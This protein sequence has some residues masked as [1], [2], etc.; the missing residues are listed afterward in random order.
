[1][2]QDVTTEKTKDSLLW[3]SFYGTKMASNIEPSLLRELQN[4][5]HTERAAELQ[6]MQTNM[7]KFWLEHSLPFTVLWTKMS[8]NNRAKCLRASFPNIL[9]SATDRYYIV[10]EQKVY[11]KA[12]DKHLFLAPEVTVEFLSSASNLLDLIQNL[13]D[14]HKMQSISQLTVRRLRELV[15]HRAYPF[16]TAVAAAI[17]K[18][19][20]L[21]EGSFLRMDTPDSYG[22]PYNVQ[23]P[24][25]IL[26]E[27]I[28]K[29]G[30]M[31]YVYEFDIVSETL[32]FIYTVVNAVIDK[33]GRDSLREDDVPVYSQV[34]SNVESVCG[35]CHKG[36][37]ENVILMQCKQCL[38]EFY[39]SV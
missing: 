17:E 29:L 34:P 30:C 28:F 7:N 26:N 4:Q 21:K 38:A 8:N 24:A 37:S 6:N 36:K 32:H 11:E 14:L 2:N 23:S 27:N 20:P 12:Y 25:A 31:M 13:G 10:N 16:T 19:T 39:C 15:V 22:V 9:H 5:Q 18:E 33:S 35:F 3:K 1:M